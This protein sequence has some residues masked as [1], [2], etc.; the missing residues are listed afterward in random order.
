MRLNTSVCIW[1][2]VYVYMYRVI[3]DFASPSQAD[4]KQTSVKPTISPSNTFDKMGSKNFFLQYN[5][6][7]YK[8]NIF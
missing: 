1:V 5:G 2:C 4:N 3:Q 8:L 6:K 7:Q